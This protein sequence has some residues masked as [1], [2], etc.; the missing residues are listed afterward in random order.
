M[1]LLTVPSGPFRMGGDEADGVA[2]DGEGPVRDV[3]VSTFL[4][5]SACVTNAEFAAFV[6][7]TGHVTDAEHFGWSFV[8]AGLLADA[9]RTH[10]LAEGLPGAPWWLAVAGATWA[11]PEGPG[12]GLSGRGDHPVVH[13]SWHDATAYAAWTG[14]RLPTETE[15]EKAARGGLVGARY[16]W[17]DELTPGGAHRANLWQGDFPR[18]NTGEDGYVA[19]APVGAFLPNG[20]GLYQMAGNVWEWTAD[21]FSAIWHVAARPATRVDPTGPPSGTTKV[22]R[23]GSY[24]CHASYCNRYR[25]AAR[26]RSTPDSTI[27]NTG[28][29]CAADPASGRAGR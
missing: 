21:W 23:G 27:G 4:L 5:A 1:E 28:F 19:T 2:G 15:W 9:A 29:R 18:A 26:T 11:A 7:A 25:M 12:S 13:V 17:G 14:Q 10:V 16:P 6:D 20:Y 24:L 8:F 3:Y 22:L